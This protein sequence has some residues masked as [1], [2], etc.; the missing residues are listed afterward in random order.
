MLFKSL[1]NLRGS[2]WLMF[3]VLVPL[4]LIDAGKSNG[5]TPSSSNILTVSAGNLAADDLASQINTLL[6]EELEKEFGPL[7][8]QIMDDKKEMW[9]RMIAIDYEQPEGK[10]LDDTWG[11]KVVEALGRLGI[12]AEYEGSEVRADGQ[13]IAGREASSMQFT[14]SR[15]SEEPDVIGFTAMFM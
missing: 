6:K 12:A 1:N 5:D 2:V 4:F 8:D 11:E 9:G 14:T 3:F 7:Y 13:E 15:G 10:R